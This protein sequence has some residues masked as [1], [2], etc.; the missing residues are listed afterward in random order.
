[1]D[2]IMTSIWP[3]AIDGQVADGLPP[4][5]AFLPTVQLFEAGAD[6]L[7]GRP[8]G[9][10]AR[11][12]VV[13]DQDL[14]REGTIDPGAT[15]LN[16]RR[17]DLRYGI[18]DRSDLRQADM[19][20]AILTGASLREAILHEIKAEQAILRGADLRYAQFVPQLSSD[21]VYNGVIFRGADLRGANLT[22][23]TLIGMDMEGAL[24]EGT[25]LTDAQMDA[26][27]RADAEKQGAR[28]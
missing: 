22:G 26:D 28:F 11:N 25:I 9:L 7:S 16:L 12:L 6:V 10:F 8:V 1:M 4:R 21:R 14:V 17:R 24:L 3:E 27:Q 18:F 19:T 2:R 5:Q 20:G 23:A 15:S 13:V